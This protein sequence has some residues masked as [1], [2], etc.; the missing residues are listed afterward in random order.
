VKRIIITTDHP[1][2]Y[3]GVTLAGNCEVW[4]RDRLLEAQSVLAAVLIGSPRHAV[5]AREKRVWASRRRSRCQTSQLPARVT[6]L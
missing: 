2:N 5:T 6:P 3:K 1:E 4:H